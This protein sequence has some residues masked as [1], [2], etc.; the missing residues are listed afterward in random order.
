MKW[1]FLVARIKILDIQCEFTVSEIC[2]EF[3]V[4]HTGIGAPD[5]TFSGLF[6][7]GSARAALTTTFASTN[8]H[9]VPPFNSAEVGKFCF[10]NSPA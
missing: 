2:S 4:L 6:Y 9:N 7:P 10:K 8:L 5:T 3:S 1:K